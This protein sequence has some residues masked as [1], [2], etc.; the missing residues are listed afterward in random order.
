MKDFFAIISNDS[1]S[2]S[3]AFFDTHIELIQQKAFVSYLD[4]LLTLKPKITRTDQEN[5]ACI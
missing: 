1:Q 5:E 3:N 2:A 4:F